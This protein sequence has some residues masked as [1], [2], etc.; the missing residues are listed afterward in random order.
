MQ[1]KPYSCC[2]GKAK[3]SESP[4]CNLLGQVHMREMSPE[5]EE[6]IKTG[7][8]YLVDLAGSENVNRQALVCPSCHR[9]AEMLLHRLSATPLHA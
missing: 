5:G 8:L 1:C 2:K 4:D 9:Q 6:V 3:G 7:K